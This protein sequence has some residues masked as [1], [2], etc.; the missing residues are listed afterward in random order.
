[1]QFRIQLVHCLFLFSIFPVISFL[2]K[3]GEKPGNIYGF[4]FKKI[5]VY[6]KFSP[7]IYDIPFL[8]AVK[9]KM[10]KTSGNIRALS[11]LQLSRFLF[12]FA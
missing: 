12:L 8:Y 11:L 2:K 10:F 6:L 4:C 7:N 5:I 3:K 9:N 1:M